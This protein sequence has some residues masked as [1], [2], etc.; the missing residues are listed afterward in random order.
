MVVNRVRGLGLRR[1]VV[2]IAVQLGVVN[3]MLGDNLKQQQRLDCNN[4]HLG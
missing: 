3:N 1:G 2:G 4:Q